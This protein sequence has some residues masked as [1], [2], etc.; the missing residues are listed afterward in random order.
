M[1]GDYT[2]CSPETIVFNNVKIGKYCSIGYRVQIGC[3]EHP[4]FF[5]STSPLIY[6]NNFMQKF[7]EWPIDDYKD[8]VIIGNDVWIGSNV[9]ILQG[10]TIG[11]GAI[12]AAGA[13][14]NKN[15]EPYSIVGGVPAKEIKKRF[16]KDKVERLLTSKW[17]DKSMNQ[18]EEFA[19]TFYSKGDL[20]K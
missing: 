1:I 19:E 4:A 14:V 2:Y 13:V 7:I 9:V 6:R 20:F 10:V 5:F 8:P 16:D 3:P 15:V 11:D 18:I 12:I 17:W